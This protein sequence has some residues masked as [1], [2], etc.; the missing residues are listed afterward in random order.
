MSVS[1]NSPKRRN[2]NRD[3][4]SAQCLAYVESGT[5]SVASPPGSLSVH[6]GF[7]CRQ[8][9]TDIPSDIRQECPAIP[10]FPPRLAVVVP[11]QTGVPAVVGP[12]EVRDAHDL[13]VSQGQYDYIKVMGLITEARRL[14]MK[15]VKGIM[16][17]CRV[18]LQEEMKVSGMCPHSHCPVICT[19]PPDLA[20]AS[21]EYEESVLRIAHEATY[22]RNL[23]QQGPT[24]CTLQCRSF[25]AA[26]FTGG[27]E[28]EQERFGLS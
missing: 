26:S 12:A 7:G 11:M 19:C 24:L 16:K 3:A 1:M 20:S 5:S 14:S 25:P 22:W 28:Q 4:P 9:S 27:N 6:S 8:V 23:R 10:A 18:L 17:Q 2:K 13:L 21:R 15:K